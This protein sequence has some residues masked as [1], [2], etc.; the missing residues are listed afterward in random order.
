[1]KSTKKILTSYM[2]QNRKMGPNCVN[3]QNL[4]I[5]PVLATKLL[6]ISNAI[7]S[8]LALGME[9]GKGGTPLPKAYGM[10]RLQWDEELATFAQVLANQCVL[11]HD[12]C[13]ASRQT[14]GL[15]RYTFPDWNPMTKV[16]PEDEGTAPGLNQAKLIYAIKQS[17]KSWYIQKASVTPEMIT[18]YPDWLQHPTRQ[19]GK[20]YLEMITGHA[21]HMGCGISAYEEYTYRNN[22]AALN[23]NA[24][25]PKQKLRSCNG[26]NCVPAI[27]LLPIIAMEDAPPTI[28]TQN[29]FNNDTIDVTGIFENFNND[30]TK[31]NSAIKEANQRNDFEEMLREASSNLQQ[32]GSQTNNEPSWKTQNVYVAKTPLISRTELQAQ[33]IHKG[34]DHVR[35]SANKN[36]RKSLFSKVHKFELP[37]KTQIKKD[38][39]PRKDFSKVQKLVKTYLSTKRNSD[40]TLSNNEQKIN[41]RVNIQSLNL[42]DLKAKVNTADAEKPISQR[43]QIFKDNLHDDIVIDNNSISNLYLKT[44]NEDTDK[45][46]MYLLDN[47]EQEVNHI[48]L[49]QTEKEILDDKLRKIYGRI[50]NKPKDFISSKKFKD[51]NEVEKSDFL[52][53]ENTVNEHLLNERRNNAKKH[54]GDIFKGDISKRRLITDSNHLDVHKRLLI[55]ERNS[56]EDFGPLK[57]RL[58]KPINENDYN[59]Y[60]DLKYI[61][62]ILSR[63]RN[64]LVEYDDRYSKKLRD[65]ISNGNFDENLNRRDSRMPDL[66]DEKYAYKN[67]NEIRQKN[68]YP[69]HL[70]SESQMSYDRRKYY[71][72]KIN[73]LEQKL[74]KARSRRRHNKPDGDRQLRPVQPDRPMQTKTEKNVFYVPDRA[75]S[76]HGF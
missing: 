17:T 18:K 40:K 76:V 48:N 63:N 34:L 49:N 33:S 22:Y 37:I 26:K 1:M 35:P 10:L 53:F 42:S 5:T 3:Y 71:Q 54:V 36:A 16:L 59:I 32:A 57:K 14:A 65:L 67:Y 66:R 29:R 39:Q 38:V 25:S 61:N 19:A 44:S 70:D 47:L 21:T 31:K 28:L 58:E 50:S 8:K 7:R 51:A 15:V 68:Y 13:R 46:L 73:Y 52:K 43:Y 24:T 20:L 69:N 23:Y 2:F 56:N 55:K 11:R 9:K 75:R 27:V 6:E 30:K 60:S 45:K 74:Q 62:R 64:A 72:E 4:T 41:R 12:M